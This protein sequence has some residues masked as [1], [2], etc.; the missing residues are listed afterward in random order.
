LRPHLLGLRIWPTGAAALRA[1]ISIS[2]RRNP[3]FSVGFTL[4]R[5]GGRWLITTV[6]LPD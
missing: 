3:P 1:S 4:N 5:R 2:D 6:S